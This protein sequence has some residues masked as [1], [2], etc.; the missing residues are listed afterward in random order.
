MDLWLGLQH[1]RF[2]QFASRVGFCPLHK[3]QLLLELYLVHIE[4]CRIFYEKYRIFHEDSNLTTETHAT[5]LVV[6]RKLRS[7]MPYAPF[8]SNLIH[9]LQVIKR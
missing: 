1:T 6:L 9:T 3:F 7:T 5:F 4:Q 2:L 8:L